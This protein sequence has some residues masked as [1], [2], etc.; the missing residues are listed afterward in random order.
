M[1]KKVWFM[2]ET[3]FILSLKD[4]GKLFK[5]E[6][7]ESEVESLEDF[8]EGWLESAF[9]LDEVEGFVIYNGADIYQIY[10]IGDLIDYLNK[11]KLM[12]VFSDMC[13]KKSK[14]VRKR[15]NKKGGKDDRKNIKTRRE[16]KDGF[17]NVRG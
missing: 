5:E 12:Y 17:K 3:E 9:D 7:E 15:N 10:T 11:E 6:I 4:A 2:S 8:L 14:K 16:I 1:K 13:D